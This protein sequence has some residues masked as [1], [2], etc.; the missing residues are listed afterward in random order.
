MTRHPFPTLVAACGLILG[1]GACQALPILRPTPTAPSDMPLSLPQLKSV[2]LDEFGEIF[3]CDPDYYPVA[4]E[5]E[6]VLARQRFP[7]L[8]ADAQ[9]FPVLL[10]RLG[11]QP[12]PTY[13]PEEQ[14]AIY[15]EHKK[16]A[17]VYTEPT[18]AG[19]RFQLRVTDGETIEALEGEIDLFARIRLERRQPSSDMCPICLA[20]GTHIA[21]PGGPIAVEDLRPGMLVWSENHRGQRV[22]VEI[23][24]VG[25]TPVAQPHQMLR[26]TLADGRTLLASPGHPLPNGSSLSTLQAGAEFAGSRI[27]DAETVGYRARFTFDLRAGGETGWYWAEGILLASSLESSGEWLVVGGQ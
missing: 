26:L 9:E 4:R 6:A 21:T 16:L 19:Y 15:R 11:I 8:A 27:L 14:L 18:G 17:A 25:M 13:S 22:A 2:L 7:E 1:L 5:D 23:E 3:F 24:A 10:R 20:A 12:G